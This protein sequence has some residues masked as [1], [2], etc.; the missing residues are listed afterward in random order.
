MKGIQPDWSDYQLRNSRY[1]QGTDR[2]N[3][4]VLVKRF[5]EEYPQLFITTRGEAMGIDVCATLKQIGINLVF[6]PQEETYRVSFAEK[7]INDDI[8]NQ[9]KIKNKILVC[10]IV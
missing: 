1:L 8:I 6:P 7:F 10:K 2:K 9:Y 4:L 5:I 3:H